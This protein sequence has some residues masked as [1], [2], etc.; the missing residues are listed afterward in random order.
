MDATA[1]ARHVKAHYAQGEERP[2]GSYTG[3]LGAYGAGI[4]ALGIIG[5]ARR[6]R[7]PAE[8]STRD[9]LLAIVATGKFSRIIAKD[10]IVSPIRAP[11][12]TFQGT[13]GDSELAEEVSGTGGQKAIGEF[14]TCPFCVG[15]WLATGFV[16]GASLAPR[17]TRA[18]A[19]VGTITFGSDVLQYL[20][21]RLQSSE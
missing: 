3:L 2:L 20:Y 10:P 8:Y 19:M 9:L 16:A 7:L 21:S 6:K 12:T 15:Q 5:W 13:S 1:Y 4:G 17:A 11:F 14:L 18:V